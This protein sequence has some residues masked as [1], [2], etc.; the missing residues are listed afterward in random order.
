MEVSVSNSP[1]K[2]KHAAFLNDFLK[3]EY[4]QDLHCYTDLICHDGCLQL[5]KLIAGLVFPELISSLEFQ[6]SP[7]AQILVPDWSRSDID[8]KIN[9]YFTITKN[10]S[11]EEIHEIHGPLI[12]DGSV[13]VITEEIVTELAV[14]D[15]DDLKE[16]YSIDYDEND[17]TE[18]INEVQN[19]ESFVLD[20]EE[21]GKENQRTKS[22]VKDSKF[23]LFPC[24]QICKETNKQCDKSYTS[25]GRLEKHNK[26]VHQVGEPN[27]C[28]KCNQIFPSKHS[29]S[30]H[31]RMCPELPQNCDQSGVVSVSEKQLRCD[32]CGKG[33][34]H[35]SSLVAHV[36]T[37]TKPFKCSFCEESF[38]ERKLLVAHQ[39]NHHGHTG[40]DPIIAD[41]HTC[42]FCPKIFPAKSQLVLHERSHTKEKP[43]Q[44][45]QCLKSFAVKCNLSAHERIHF[46]ESKR[47]QCRHPPC[48]RM[49]S[50]TTE[51]KDHEN[52]HTGERPHVCP[53]CGEKYKRSANLWRH[54]KKC[55]R[56]HGMKEKVEIVDEMVVD[57]HTEFI[58]RDEAEGSTAKYEI[59]IIE[60]KHGIHADV[61]CFQQVVDEE[62]IY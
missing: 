43:Y 40:E 16:D 33:F 51:R 48:K 27:I 18:E 39:L 30:K 52:T 15:D 13:E 32:Q 7:S 37:H 47:Y 60:P 3:L 50:H 17:R 49:F 5:N 10:D 6:T 2:I 44:C 20:E 12:T 22:K 14:D 26:T 24:L 58:V 11:F 55:Q 8:N 9:K 46:G 41:L 57:D 19:F 61:G 25:L 45:S 36:N 56:I 29:L 23:G 34:K 59:I 28:K 1:A 53:G 31:V 38:A 21:S 54:K 35:T 4:S 42:S 62:I